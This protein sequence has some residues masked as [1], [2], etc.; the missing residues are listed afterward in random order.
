MEFCH[1]FISIAIF[2]LI[3][4]PAYG[5]FFEDDF[6]SGN[7]T[8]W[9]GDT[10]RFTITDGELQLNDSG[11]NE[12]ILWAN[13]ATGLQD[14]TR[15]SFYVR[16][17]FA[18]SSNNFSRII[19][20]S[21]SPDFLGAYR[22]YYLQIGGISGTD[23][24]L[25]LYRQDGNSRT[26]LL[27]GTLG[28]V[29]ELPSQARVLITRTPD[30]TWTLEADYEGG[31]NLQEEGQIVDS[32]YS[33]LA[34]FGLQCRYTSLRSTDFFFDDI[35]VGPLFV[36]RTPPALVTVEPFGNDSLMVFFDEAI[37]STSATEPSNY[38]LDPA[39]GNPA[40]ATLG[41]LPGQVMLQFSGTFV[42]ETTY[43]FSAENIADLNG[44]I[45]PLQQ[46][47]FTF[48]EVA[49]PQQGDLLISE[50]MADPSPSQGLPEAEYIE[51][52]NLSNV[53]LRLGDLGIASGGTPSPLPDSLLRAG[54][55]VIICD[56]AF[57]SA[58]S[59]FGK[60]IPVPD[61]P[62]LSNGGD[63]VEIQRNGAIL[64]S[65]T[66]D[67][68]WY[69]DSEKAQG[70]FSL[71][72]IDTSQVADCAGNWIASAAAIGGTPGNANSVVDVPIE[73]DPPM[74]LQVIP[75]EEGELLVRYDEPVR[76]GT[77]DAP[78]L[79]Q[80]VPEIPI[81][82]AMLQGGGQEVLLLLQDPLTPSVQYTL[83]VA[84]GL[85]DCLG[86]TN[87]EVQTLIFGL[88]EPPLPNDLI[89]NE[90]LFEPQTGGEDFVELFNTSDKIID[91]RGM[92]LQNTAKNSGNTSQTIENSFLVF[93]NTYAVI[94][95]IPQ[96]I[97]DRYTVERSDWLVEND[98][99]TLDADEG[100]ITL[101][102]AGVV[103]DSFRYSDDLHFPLLDN[104]RGVS[105]ERISSLVP[106]NQSGN[107][108]SASSG[109]GFATPTAINSQQ[110]D[111]PTEPSNDFIRIPTKIFSPDN[112][113]FQDVL[114][115][116]YEVGSPGFVLNVRILDHYGF[117]V[118][119]L[120]QN[121]LLGINGQFKWDGTNADGE[122]ARIGIYV[123][124]SEIF[125]PE[126]NVSRQKESIVLA[127]RLD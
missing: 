71:E 56:E 2:W 110:T 27:E 22:G 120:V 115:I 87:P 41:A 64:S 19:L 60:V 5:Q 85:T 44:N 55:V 109:V 23:D 29:G 104:T 91:L 124:W 57:A 93:P 88:P 102:S 62:T 113:G 52:K 76:S 9:N 26:E 31:N 13:A 101:L 116:E 75:L 4:L 6:S 117:E 3:C 123:V 92:V 45:A 16:Q 126:G 21:D 114:L 86:N 99:P 105:L 119:N 63:V 17:E 58:F 14:T 108:H 67:I 112:D 54:E 96:D 94:T 72:L 127:G 79:Y 80:L 33:S 18:P 106:T 77:A 121:E 74:L 84:E 28:A 98:L 8:Q 43:T 50:I 81:Q 11:Q 59:T 34:F 90:I 70:G 95:D 15:W 49:E 25:V 51:L 40:A 125:D 47:T 97:L 24:A 68:S 20:A 83:T 48:L 7:L 82:E 53:T 12:S 111:L 38:L 107:W 36:D 32:T 1:S 103:I 39:L 37:D 89:I 66:Y 118:R 65:I 61:F 42:D 35:L 100:N 78:D 73:E 30:G 122:K 10:A 69:R 46:Q